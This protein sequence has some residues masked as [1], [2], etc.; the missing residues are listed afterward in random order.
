MQLI[1]RF[2]EWLTFLAHV[3]NLLNLTCR[4]YISS[5]LSHHMSEL[6]K[7][8]PEDSDQFFGD[9]TFSRINQIKGRQQA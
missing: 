9:N 4:N 1:Q 3:I 2:T 8:V 6:G 5:V 7:K